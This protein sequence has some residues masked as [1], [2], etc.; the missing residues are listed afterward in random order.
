ME[1][2]ITEE[3]KQDENEETETDIFAAMEYYDQQYANEM[4]EN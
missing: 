3:V 2:V 1:A 4:K